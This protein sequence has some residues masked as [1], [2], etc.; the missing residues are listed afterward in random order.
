MEFTYP[1]P[2]LPESP[3]SEIQSEIDNFDSD[4][5][6]MKW[7]FWGTPYQDFWKLED[8]ML[9]LKALPHKMASPLKKSI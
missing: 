4:K 6:D 2:D 9:K 1:V 8:G 7:V 3:A 5:L